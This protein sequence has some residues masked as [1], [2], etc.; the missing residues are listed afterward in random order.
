MKIL[1]VIPARKNSKRL[2]NKNIRMFN[3]KTLIENSIIFAKKNFKKFKI[4]VSTDSDTIRKISLK[5]DVL[6]PWLRPKIL[7]KDKSSTISVLKHALKWS[8]KLYGNF[9]AILLLQPTTPFR[10]KID[11][12][13]SLK[14]FFKKK[15]F[16]NSSLISVKTEKKY[17]K[18]KKKIIN[19]SNNKIFSPSGSFY[20]IGRNKLKNKKSILGKHTYG[21]LITLKKYNIDIDTQV[22]LK[23]AQKFLQS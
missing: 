23:E 5:Y 13:F 7:S 18:E 1:V 17:F 6:C 12:N 14:M 9:D 22:D 4:I 11:I 10:R 19:L 2:K 3:K 8:E 20:I 15:N 16:I 21:Y